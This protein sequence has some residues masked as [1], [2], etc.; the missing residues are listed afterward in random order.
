MRRIL[1]FVLVGLGVFLVALAFVVR[2]FMYPSAAVIPYELG[3]PEKGERGQQST[4]AGTVSVLD[5][6][7][8]AEK[9][10]DAVR[11]GV[12]VT[13]IRTLVTDLSAK[14][15]EK[16]GDVTVWRVGLVVVD[17]NSDSQD[18]QPI[19]DVKLQ[20]VCLDRS[21]SE[22]VSPCSRS[23]VVTCDEE[24]EDEDPCLQA[25]ASDKHQR[26][27]AGLQF[28]FPFQTEQRTYKYYDTTILQATEARFAGA[29]E[30]NGLGVYK[31]VQEIPETLIA[32]LDEEHEQ[33]P[34]I[35]FDPKLQKNVPAKQYY[36]TVRT[37]WVE[38][39]S[40]QIVKGTDTSRQVLRGPD[41]TEELVVFDGTMT[42]VDREVDA[43]VE[44][45]ASNRSMLRLVRLW[46]PIGAGVIG[47]VL[48]AGGLLL[49]LGYRRRQRADAM[50]ENGRHRS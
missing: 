16:G 43:N 27:Q 44:A 5:K 8:I 10:R 17:D 2:L 41:G 48:I 21:T 36:Q 38:P 39:E 29:E 28:K 47:G 31:F 14:E 30:L 26:T 4:A 50:A 11:Q 40:G 18:P 1:P 37:F 6:G 46:V 49:E 42:M 19:T 23:Y 34:G 12:E 20:S 7:L 24:A 33:V 45:A 9:G 25:Q 15:S 22:S 35:L 13:A 32:E 3:D